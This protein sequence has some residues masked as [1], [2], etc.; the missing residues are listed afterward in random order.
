MVETLQL[1]PLI[2]HPFSG[3]GNTEELLEG[4]R[5]SLA[6]NGMGRA[7]SPRST[8]KPAIDDEEELFRRV[9]IGRYQEIRMLLFLGKDLF[10]WMQQCVDFVSRSAETN[11]RVNE[12]SFAALVVESPP[13]AVQLKLDKWGVSDRRAIFSRAIGV[14]S[15]FSSPPPSD[16]LAPVFLQNYHRYADHAY[17]CFQHLKA[18]HSLNPREYDFEM[19][20][21]EEYARLLS[22]QWQR[23]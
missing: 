18:F 11:L 6:L 8:E 9:L 21:S 10:R 23:V 12:Q 5:A 13:P 4:S 14:N 1:P 3:G 20:A 19:Y 16:T 2:L 15:L 7:G 17:I 22:E